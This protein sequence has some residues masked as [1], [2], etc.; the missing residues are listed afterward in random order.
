MEESSI[1]PSNLTIGSCV[2]APIYANKN[3]NKKSYRRA[4]IATIHR[5]EGICSVF[6]ETSAAA[7]KYIVTPICFQSDNETSGDD[8]PISD[9]YEINKDELEFFENG[10]SQGLSTDDLKAKADYLF[11]TVHDAASAIDY[12]EAALR[13]ISSI[14]IGG[15]VIINESGKA[16]VAEVD[17]IDGDNL[18]VTYLDAREGTIAKGKVLIGLHFQEKQRYI[19]AKILLNLA[20]C[21]NALVDGL[22]SSKLSDIQAYRKAAILACTLSLSCLTCQEVCSDRTILETKVE[23]IRARLYLDS[24][25]FDHAKRDLNTILKRDHDNKAA[26][27]LKIDMEQRISRKKKTDRNLAKNVCRWINKVTKEEKGEG[28]VIID[29]QLDCASA[30]DGDVKKKQILST[31]FAFQNMICLCFLLFALYIANK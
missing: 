5:D 30:V 26:R 4:V 23:Y 12:Y 24:G 31:D 14:E 25:K 18:D 27:L 19:Q 13:N 6:Y 16:L 20:R 28:N 17:C 2:R 29:E 22:S 21:F 15:M 8:I 3:T 10:C 9:L 1:E 7:S 11:A